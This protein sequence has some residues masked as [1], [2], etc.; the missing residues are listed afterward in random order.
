MS[1]QRT[2][3]PQRETVTELIGKGW[4]RKVEKQDSAHFGKAFINITLDRD[5]ENVTLKKGDVLQLWPN[6][7]R[8]GKR[9]ADWRMS[10]VTP[11]Q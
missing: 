7:K 1:V 9:D 8:E 5:I 3:N 2:E 6:H 4:E 11:V 10:V